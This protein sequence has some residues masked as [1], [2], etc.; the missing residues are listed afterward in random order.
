M[1]TFRTSALGEVRHSIR[2]RTS[3]LLI[4]VFCVM[5]TA[6]AG[7]GFLTNQTVTDV[8]NKVISQNLTTAPNPFDGVS[9]LYYARNSVI[10]VLLIGSLMAITLGVQSGLRERKLKIVDLVLTRPI[11]IKILMLGKLAGIGI[12]LIAAIAF[13]MILS[14]IILSLMIGGALGYS[15]SIRL[16][17]FALVTLLL[18]LGF[19][20]LGLISGIRSRHE[21]SALVLPIVLWSV[22]AF[23]IPQV[24][25]AARPTALLNPVPTLGVGGGYF[26]W[27]GPFTAPLSI[28]EQF[29]NASSVILQDPNVQPDLAS[30]LL[31]IFIFALVMVLVLLSSSRQT[32]RQSLND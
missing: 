7:I 13:S 32:M 26:D 21:A 19:A 3:G 17:A 31:S 14:W 27:I 1:T 11:N 30:S 10:Y 20:T 29:K 4:S 8:Y 23:V 15:D 2:E 9:N 22:I 16:V 24:G 18:L 12:V 25:T 5:V 6:S 28:T